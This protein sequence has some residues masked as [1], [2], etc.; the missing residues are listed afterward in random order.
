MRISCLGICNFHPRIRHRVFSFSTQQVYQTY[1][2]LW[3]QT[4][5]NKLFC[6]LKATNNNQ[7]QTHMPAEGNEHHQLQKK[8]LQQ[9]GL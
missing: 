2:L 8:K 4:L 6:Q 5:Q 9:H 1:G 3:R 7:E